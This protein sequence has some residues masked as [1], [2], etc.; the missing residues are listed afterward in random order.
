MFKIKKPKTNKSR[1]YLKKTMRALHILLTL[2]QG[3]L[4]FSRLK[5]NK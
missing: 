2:L 5:Y 4:H 1:Y 3:G